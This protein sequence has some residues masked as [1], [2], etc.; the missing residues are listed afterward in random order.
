[1]KQATRRATS[2][3]LQG[4]RAFSAAASSGEGYIDVHTHMYFPKY[5]E[6]L[7]NRNEVPKV[8]VYKGEERLVI[9]PGEDTEKTT[10]TGRPIG[11]EY[12]DFAQ[13]IA[14]MDEHNIDISVVSLANPWLDFLPPEEAGSIARDLNDSLEKD[15]GDS[16]GRLL[17]FGVLPFQNMDAALAEVEHCAKNLKNIKG[18]IIGTHGA[19][20]GLQHR[21]LLPLYKAVEASGHLLFVHPHYGIGNEFYTDTGHALFLACGFTFETTVSIARLICSGMLDEVPR[22]KLLLSHSGGTLPFLGG[23]L[24]SCVHHEPALRDKLEH[25]PTEYMKRFYYD[26]V[27]YHT[28]ALECVQK[29][30]GADR[31]MFGTDHPFFPPPDGGPKWVSTVKNQEILEASPHFADFRSGNARRLLGLE[32]CLANMSVPGC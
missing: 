13:K 32:S 22:L 29:L 30:V 8:I 19:G 4:R 28:P 14:F 6:M 15:C 23:R 27:I 16:N 10:A 31:L 25:P 2:S 18:F 3:L 11:S 5:M 12:H 1:M 20:H 7:R 26:A 24:D 17:G 21:D 9:L